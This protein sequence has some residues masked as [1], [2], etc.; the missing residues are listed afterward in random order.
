MFFRFWPNL[1]LNVLINEVLNQ[2]LRG[3]YF[4]QVAIVGISLFM[5]VTIIFHL[6]LGADLLRMSRSDFIQLC[7]P[8][9]GIRLNNA[10]QAR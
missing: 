4:Y 6:S 1:S 5:H 10:L 8:A 2:K 3:R 9:D 7:G